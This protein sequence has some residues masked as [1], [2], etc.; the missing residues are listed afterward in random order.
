MFVYGSPPVASWYAQKP[1][2]GKPSGW[3][4]CGLTTMMFTLCPDTLKCAAPFLASPAMAPADMLPGALAALSTQ[5][6]LSTEP[7][8]VGC[9]P[10]PVYCEVTRD[11]ASLDWPSPVKNFVR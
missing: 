10:L 7:V 6:P 9:S 5:V 4:P 2:F 8:N 11:Q 1:A 3:V